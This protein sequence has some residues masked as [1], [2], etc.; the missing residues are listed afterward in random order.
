VTIR[1]SF[2]AIADQLWIGHSANSLRKG[3]GLRRSV[4]GGG[5]DGDADR[6]GFRL[7][8]H[9]ATQ[10]LLF[11]HPQTGD[12][13]LTSVNNRAN[14][15]E[16]VDSTSVYRERLP[17]SGTATRATRS[18]LPTAS[19]T[20]A[21][22]CRFVSILTGRC[23]VVFRKPAL[24]RSRTLPPR[25]ETP[26]HCRRRMG[27]QFSAGSRRFRQDHARPAQLLEPEFPI[28]GEVL[29]GKETYTRTI[30]A[31]ADWFKPAARLWLDLGEVKNCWGRVLAV[32]WASPWASCGDPIP[33]RG[34]R[35]P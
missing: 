10:N 26:L 15:V 14:R 24:E 30:Q 31:S 34:N 29:S 1:Q 19:P 12:G 2:Q 17:S 7:H 27:R 32:Q 13:D 20:G 25:I 6:T 16:S 18:L 9:K 35:R 22:P 3:E 28:R 33:G 5:S 23:F 21:R 8:R 11:V 4:V